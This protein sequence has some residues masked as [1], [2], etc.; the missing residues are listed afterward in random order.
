MKKLVLPLLLLSMLFA[1]CTNKQNFAPQSCTQE[2]GLCPNENATW[3][4]V[5]TSWV[6]CPSDRF[7]GGADCRG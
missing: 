1:G 3:S 4:S 2:N 5:T 7:D 6:D